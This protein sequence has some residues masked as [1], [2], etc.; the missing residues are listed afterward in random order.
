M[1]GE[2]E[3]RGKG[4]RESFLIG[5]S[6]KEGGGDIGTRSSGDLGL[7]PVMSKRLMNEKKQSN[8]TKKYTM[9][10]AI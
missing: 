1:R 6:W 4:M 5:R 3:R 7:E 9:T 2:V 8:F 10:K